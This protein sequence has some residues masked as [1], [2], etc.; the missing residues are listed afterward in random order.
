MNNT[1]TNRKP[2]DLEGKIFGSLRAIHE[3]WSEKSATRKC[4]CVCSCGKIS[5]VQIGNLKSGHTK[6][7][8]CKQAPF[9]HGDATRSKGHTKLYA[10]WK[11]M[12]ARC[13]RKTCKAY[14]YYG[15]K[16][17]SVAEGWKRYSTFKEWA[18]LNG[19]KEGLSIDRMDNIKGYCPENCQWVTLAENSRLEAVRKL[20]LKRL[21]GR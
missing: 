2:F 13:Y 14:K 9:K 7:C 4:L 20:A 8:G 11:G 5:I 1:G 10:I 21:I 17:I 16:G 12:F 18:M 3:V 19:Y 15:A 6:S